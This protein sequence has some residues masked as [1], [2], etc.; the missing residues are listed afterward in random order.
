MLAVPTLLGF[1]HAQPDETRGWIGRVALA[2]TFWVG[3]FLFNAVS[4]YLKAPHRR[5][6]A[7]RPP[8]LAYGSVTAVLGLASLALLGL[9]TAA[10]ALV[11]APLTLATWWLVDT[12][13]ERSLLSGA[14]TVAAASIFSATLVEPHL[15]TLLGHWEEAPHRA[16][17]W[18]VVGCFWYFL[19]T[20]WSVKTMIRQRGSVR[21][22]WGAIAHHLL[23]IVV[24]V[25]G[26]WTGGLGWCWVVFFVATLVRT[27]VL[28]LIGPMASP[29]RTI[30][31]MTLGLVEVVFSLALLGLGLRLQ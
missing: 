15:P 8:V 24:A 9:A 1:W 30:T 21:W 16:I 17:L 29:P 19:G 23:A 4:L 10:W 18:C 22:W 13:R 5:R 26:V 12:H 14:L 27:V 25:L 6:A 2:A 28:P 11:F 31:P 3:Y 20:V 7:L